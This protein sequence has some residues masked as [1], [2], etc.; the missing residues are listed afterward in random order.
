LKVRDF[1]LEFWNLFMKSF[2]VVA[3]PLSFSFDD[4]YLL[5]YLIK[6][7]FLVKHYFIKFFDFLLLQHYFL[8][9]L[10]VF[11]SHNLRR[12]FERLLDAWY[13]KIV[14]IFCWCFF[15]HFL[16][17]FRLILLNSKL[18]CLWNIDKL[19]IH[20]SSFSFLV[21]NMNLV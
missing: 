17:K 1:L 16:L 9:E 5:S 19:C 11:L 14:I 2:H 7:G 13:Q 18:K 8:K 15:W 12:S 3:F 20:L 10:A 21:L 4:I 6:M